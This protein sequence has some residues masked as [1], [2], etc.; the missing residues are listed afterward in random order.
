M[1]KIVFSKT[2][3][4]DFIELSRNNPAVLRRVRTALESIAKDPRSGKPLRL[5]LKG[6]WSY[7]VGSY[8]I[9]YAIERGKLIVYLLTIGHRSEVYG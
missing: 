9:I 7:R 8:R 1:Y 3:E 4:N 5:T 2:A 6:K